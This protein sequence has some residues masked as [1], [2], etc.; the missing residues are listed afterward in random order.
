F[1]S[2]ITKQFFVSFILYLSAEVFVRS[3]LLENMCSLKGSITYTGG[4]IRIGS[5][6]CNTDNCTPSQPTLPAVSS[7]SNNLTCRTCISASS[8]S[9][10]TSDTI[11][12][13]GNENMCLLESSVITTGTL[14][15][16][17]RTFVR[18]HF[19]T[20]NVKNAFV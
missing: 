20:G 19:F 17:I 3:C 8:A 1:T 10:Y 6:C 11:Q 15:K 9:C 7:Q 14:R 2:L 18:T 5:S 16:V 4:T 12:C 13:T